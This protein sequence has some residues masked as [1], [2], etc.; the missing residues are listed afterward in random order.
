MDNK[1]TVEIEIEFA[2]NNVNEKIEKI[3]DTFAAASY[4]LDG[5]MS[6]QLRRISSMFYDASDSV[7]RNS[8]AMEKIDQNVTITND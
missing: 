6:M 2:G 4:V 8:S 1:T 5:Q 7:P 3:G